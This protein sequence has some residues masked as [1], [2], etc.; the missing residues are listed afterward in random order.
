MRVPI[1]RLK[2]RC[3]GPAQNNKHASKG[4]RE[5]QA[6]EVLNVILTKVRENLE[7]LGARGG[8]GSQISNFQEYG[9]MGQNTEFLFGG[10]GR[11]FSVLPPSV[12]FK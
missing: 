11:H 10:E 5:G 6:A 8:K 12:C 9:K 3:C 7:S 4:P 1:W 2:R